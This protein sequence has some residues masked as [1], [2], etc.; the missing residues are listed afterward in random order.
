M[1]YLC[2]DI[3][4]PPS[5]YI[6]IF[7]NNPTLNRSNVN[8][9]IRYDF[10]LK[11]VP[12]DC[13]QLLSPRVISLSLFILCFLYWVSCLYVWI[14]YILTYI[15]MHNP[16]LLLIVYSQPTCQYTTYFEC[17]LWVVASTITFCNMECFRTY[18]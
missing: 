11:W 15:L 10:E 18:R 7:G 5:I 9:M 6:R 12:S 14:T 3:R 1:I 8:K 16:P 4:I 17:A 13:F 2:I